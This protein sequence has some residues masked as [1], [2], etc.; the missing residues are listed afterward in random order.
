M[1]SRKKATAERNVPGHPLIQWTPSLGSL[2]HNPGAA[3]LTWGCFR[4][5]PDSS[6]PPY[7][8][9]SIENNKSALR[10]RSF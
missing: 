7:R 2:W 3:N 1:S 8:R 10:L 9:P 5:E 4:L 6:C